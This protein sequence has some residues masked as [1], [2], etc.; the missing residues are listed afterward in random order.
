MLTLWRFL[1]SLIL[2]ILLHPDFEI[3]VQ[4]EADLGSRSE[5]G[6]IGCLS[7]CGEYGQLVRHIV[8]PLMMMVTIT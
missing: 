6:L 4:S 5:Y 1:G 7:L 3:V 2:G 8:L